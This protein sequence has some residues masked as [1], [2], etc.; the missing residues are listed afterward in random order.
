MKLKPASK[1][2][3]KLTRGIDIRDLRGIAKGYVS[4]EGLKKL[5]SGKDYK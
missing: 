1:V 5:R 2:S 4:V 3:V